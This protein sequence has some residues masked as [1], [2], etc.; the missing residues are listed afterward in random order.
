VA[1]L[2][3]AAAASVLLLL[4]PVYEGACIGVA[5]YGP[6]GA[7]CRAGVSHATLLDENG[8]HVLWLLAA[9]VVL[10]AIG[11]LW[12]RRRARLV[13]AAGLGAFALL[14]GFTIGAAYLP[15]TIAMTIAAR[16]RS[17]GRP[18]RPRRRRSASEAV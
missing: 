6:G 16:G 10:A 7:G 17:A 14:T 3:L 2:A 13:A 4:V 9:P 5:D 8:A 15:A 18:A 1:S 11:A 12:R